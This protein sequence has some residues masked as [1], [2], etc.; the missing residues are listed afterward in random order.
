MP[1]INIDPQLADRFSHLAFSKRAGRE[2]MVFEFAK[3]VEPAIARAA[4]PALA[5]RAPSWL[6]RLLTQEANAFKGTFGKS[7]PFREQIPGIGPTP[8]GAPLMTPGKFTPGEGVLN[9]A[10]GLYRSP[11]R[12]LIYGTSA[13][14]AS[15]AANSSADTLHDWVRPSLKKFNSDAP[16]PKNLPDGNN[17]DWPVEAKWAVGLAGTALGSI[18][19]YHMLNKA[20]KDNVKS[21]EDAGSPA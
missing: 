14:G 3:A 20:R 2:Q 5:E 8:S 17:T 18:L 4:G 13:W 9:V 12:P 10:T 19:V 16:P 1:Q 11:T 21:D 7:S 6:S 15:A